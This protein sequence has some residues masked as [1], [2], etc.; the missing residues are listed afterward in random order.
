PNEIIKSSVSFF[1]FDEFTG[2]FTDQPASSTSDNSLSSL[3]LGHYWTTQVK[4]DAGVS[5]GNV[6]QFNYGFKANW[7]PIFRI[8]YKKPPFV[9]YNNSEE[10]YNLLMETPIHITYNPQSTQ[11]VFPFSQLQISNISTLWTATPTHT[12]TFYLNSGNITKNEMNLQENNL[13]VC[14]IECVKHN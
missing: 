4:N 6:L 3:G 7:N 2:V 12:L 9:V 5:T 13:V 14:N 10:R 8:G 11:N 1:S